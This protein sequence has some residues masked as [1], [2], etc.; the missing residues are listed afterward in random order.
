MAN[1][2]CFADGTR[3]VINGDPSSSSVIH[4]D[5][6]PLGKGSL[7][8]PRALPTAPSAT[9]ARVPSAAGVLSSVAEDSPQCS[10]SSLFS[11]VDVKL[12]FVAPIIKEGKKSHW[13]S[14]NQCLI[15]VFFMGCLFAWSILWHAS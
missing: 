4:D 11:A 12:Q 3:R 5:F 1:S 9:S 15:K 10:W 13:P 14:L 6:L 2:V 8:I 7:P